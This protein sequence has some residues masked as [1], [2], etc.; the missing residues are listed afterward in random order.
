MH[1]NTASNTQN[2]AQNCTKT[3]C[4]NSAQQNIKPDQIVHK[5][6]PN[7]RKGA[8]IHT[9]TPC[10]NSVHQNPNQK[11]ASKDDWGWLLY[12]FCV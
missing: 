11:Y 7:T 5:Y 12:R 4:N 6:A 3:P 8:Q 9:K 1:Q 2:G 10:N